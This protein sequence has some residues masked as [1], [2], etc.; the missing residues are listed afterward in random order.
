MLP[1][2]DRW[3]ADKIRYSASTCRFRSATVLC[4][5]NIPDVLLCCSLSAGAIAPGPD[6]WPKK[7]AGIQ[8]WFLTD[9]YRRELSIKDGQRAQLVSYRIALQKFEPRP[10]DVLLL[11]EAVGA[12]QLLNSSK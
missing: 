9:E 10:G 3:R 5:C 4:V 1:V 7:M 2:P 12:R 8:E 11:T 6:R